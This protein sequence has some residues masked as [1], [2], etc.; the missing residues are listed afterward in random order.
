M[1]QVPYG[2]MKGIGANFTLQI[3]VFLSFFLFYRVDNG[4]AATIVTSAFKALYQNKYYHG[5]DPTQT[6]FSSFI[7]PKGSPLEV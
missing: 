3:Y 7:L 1:E 6:A 4:T 5:N 2:W